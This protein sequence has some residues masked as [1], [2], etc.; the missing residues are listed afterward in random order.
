MEACTNVGVVAP[1]T[2]YARRRYGWTIE[3]ALKTPLP[4]S[5]KGS[6]KEEDLVMSPIRIPGMG[7]PC[8]DHYGTYHPSLKAMC[9]AYGINY[10][11]F[12]IR[13]RR[14]WT[15]KDALETRATT[16]P[17]TPEYKVVNSQAKDAFL[18][19]IS[20]MSRAVTLMDRAKAEDARAKRDVLAA[21]KL[22]E[23]LGTDIGQVLRKV[24]GRNVAIDVTGTC[25]GQ[26][27]QNEAEYMPLL[28]QKFLEFKEE[29]CRLVGVTNMTMI[30]VQ[31]HDGQ[32]Y[33]NEQ[34]ML[35]V[36]G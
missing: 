24:N 6:R 11:T 19:A 18:S 9:R 20:H 14:G 2:A 1:V 32:W 21:K 12:R 23:F 22:N 25:I 30:P 31:D 35:K 7:K 29:F 3:A 27:L 4:I 34:E 10:S 26:A 36:V 17:E 16:I 5:K 15:L 33:A 8:L 28:G 13:R